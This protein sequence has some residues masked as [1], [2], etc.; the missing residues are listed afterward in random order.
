MNQGK[1]I[2]AHVEGGRIKYVA[3]FPDGYQVGGVITRDVAGR[4]T[5]MEDSTMEQFANQMVGSSI[6]DPRE[7]ENRV[8]LIEPDLDRVYPWGE[9]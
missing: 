1:I 6:D 5:T 2:E 3:E 8:R 7:S 4:H 9:K